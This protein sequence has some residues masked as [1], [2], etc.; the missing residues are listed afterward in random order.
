MKLSTPP[1]WQLETLRSRKCGECLNRLADRVAPLPGAPAGPYSILARICLS[2][3]AQ[4]R[5]LRAR[6]VACRASVLRTA[7]RAAF[8]VLEQSGSAH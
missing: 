7:R 1:T 6:A 3:R 5:G 8:R 2:C 4:L